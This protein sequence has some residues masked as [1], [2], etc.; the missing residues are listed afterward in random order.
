MSSG[1]ARGADRGIRL[2]SRWLLPGLAVAVPLLLARSLTST[3]VLGHRGSDA[4]LRSEVSRRASIGLNPLDAQPQVRKAAREDEAR[5]LL[6]DIFEVISTTGFEAGAVRS[7]QAV[8][9]AVLTAAQVLQD[10]DLPA[11]LVSLQ[12]FGRG[13]QFDEAPFA[14]VLRK[15]FQRLGATYVKLGQFIASSPTLFPETYVREF[16]QCLDKTETTPFDA[17]QRTVERDLG[18]PISAVFR[19]FE[20]KPLASASIA[21]V[22]AAV[23]KTGE[24]VA[25]KVLKPGSE[26]VMKTDLGFLYIAVRVL[27][28]ISPELARTSLVDIISEIRNSML[29][30]LDFRQELKNLETFREFLKEQKLGSVAVAP[31]P[32]PEASSKRVL[33]MSR[34]QGVP[35]IDLEGIKAYSANP[36]MTLISALNVW[37]LSVRR[38]EIFHA[39]VHAGNLLVLPDG[40]VG[41]IDFGIV[42]RV[43]PKIWK[44]VESLGLAFLAQN[45][46]GIAKSLIVMGATDQ[47]VNEEQLAQDV[48]SVLARISG[49]EPQVVLRGRT[50]GGFTAEVG[51]NEEQVTE[52]LLEVVRVANNNGLKLPREFALLVKQ[53]LYFDRY[54]KLLAPEL[55]P[56]SD[57]RVDLGL[58]RP[59]GSPDSVRRPPTPK[60]FID[61]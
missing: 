39:D 27:E 32:Y 47:A 23:L 57:E 14:R 50:E 40:R 8:Q 33:T 18:K 9:A 6:E 7:V 34:L 16:Q 22:H 1:A 44:A 5:K 49:L 35:L 29:N 4:V 20:K 46:R 13:E 25:V 17:I 52:L 59:P 60:N 28:F 51:I 2:S 31:K 15:L 41:F 10:G 37:A 45:P 54:T 12:S 48:A 30:E 24:Q 19:H 36:E 11:L 43:P 21:Q 38:C 56:L 53:A 42:G 26:S 55:N 3:F 61:V 58:S